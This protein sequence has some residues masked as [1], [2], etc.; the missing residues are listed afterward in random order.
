MNWAVKNDIKVSNS[1][2]RDA[3]CCTTNTSD[4][5]IEVKASGELDTLLGWTS[6][7]KI[8][9][10][11]KLNPRK[12]RRNIVDDTSRLKQWFLGYQTK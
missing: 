2:N 8:M 7:R 5:F 9:L 1:S 10:Y 11:R 3:N 4:L 12:E 6:N